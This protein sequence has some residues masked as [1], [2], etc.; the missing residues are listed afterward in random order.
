MHTA[1]CACS[2]ISIYSEPSLA[3]SKMFF[4]W[5]NFAGKMPPTCR[6]CRPNVSDGLDVNKC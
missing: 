3:H 1:M 5:V 2:D 4:W 6:I